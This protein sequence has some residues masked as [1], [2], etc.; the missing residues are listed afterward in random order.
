MV[1]FVPK[2][3]NCCVFRVIF[4]RVAELDAIL[5]DDDIGDY[6]EVDTD[7]VAAAA[8]ADNANVPTTGSRVVQVCSPS[9]VLCVFVADFL[10]VGSYRSCIA[11]DD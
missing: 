10:Y 3:T 11:T 7:A 4:W 1:I 2:K 8:A 9:H 5:N 6:G